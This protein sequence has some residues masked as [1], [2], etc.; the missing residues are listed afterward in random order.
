MNHVYCALQAYDVVIT[1]GGIGPT[2]D[3]VTMT[4]VAN[5]LNTQLA[6]CVH[7]ITVISPCKLYP[8]CC[9]GR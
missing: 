3:D 2:L 8:A 6:R 4:A 1:A 9:A 5:A 7:G